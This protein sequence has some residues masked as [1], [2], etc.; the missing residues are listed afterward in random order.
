MNENEI[1]TIIVETAIRVHTE[2]GPGLLESVYEAVMVRLLANRGLMV[3]A[4]VGI[5]IVF[6]GERFEIGFWA[7]IVVEGKVII[8]LK[9]VEKVLPVHKRQLNTYLRL[10]GMKLGYLLNFNE[11]LMKYGI[12]REINGIIE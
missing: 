6:E 9:A 11:E 12:T 2:L 10:T 8:E 7:D 4:Q 1:G 5:P 3:Q